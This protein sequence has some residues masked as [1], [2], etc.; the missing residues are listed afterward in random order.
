MLKN[1]AKQAVYPGRG[2]VMLKKVFKRLLDTRGQLSTADNHQWLKRSCSDFAGMATSLD[3]GLWS[4]SVSVGQEMLHHAKKVLSTIGYDLGGGGLHPL[5]Y[6]LT[7]YAKPKTIVETGVA[8]GFSS[9]AILLAIRANSYGTLFSSDF[10]YFRLPNPERFVGVLVEESLKANWHLYI[11]G[12][13]RNLP[14]ILH[15]VDTIDLFHYDSDKSY[16][17]RNF[18]M[19]CVREKLS[20]NAIILFDDIQDNSHFHDLVH[21]LDPALWR[22]FEFQGKY[23]GMIGKVNR[24]APLR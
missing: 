6:F 17:G 13:E 11:D 22:V 19:R 23:V 7:R 4:E 18:A 12:D 20:P 5:L 21:Q 1:I 24:A 8:A 9:R 10:P 15:R 16:S 3:S 14:K 2:L